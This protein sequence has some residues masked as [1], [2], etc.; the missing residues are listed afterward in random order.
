MEGGGGGGGA[1]SRYST[2]HIDTCE[3]FNCFNSSKI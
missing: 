2:V 3:L 1:L